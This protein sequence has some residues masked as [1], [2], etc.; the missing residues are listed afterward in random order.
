M[1]A[2]RSGADAPPAA[3]APF[4]CLVCFVGPSALLLTGGTGFTGSNADRVGFRLTRRPQSEKGS[5][6][7]NGHEWTR[8]KGVET[9]ATFTLMGSVLVLIRVH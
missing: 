9:D 1:T 6:T 3:L 8:I 5:S 2:H 7:T 4:V